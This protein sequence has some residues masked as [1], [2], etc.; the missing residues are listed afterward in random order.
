MLSISDCLFGDLDAGLVA[1]F[2]AE[3]GLLEN[4]MI[5]LT[6][7]GLL[8][9]E[10]VLFFGGVIGRRIVTELSGLFEAFTMV[11]VFLIARSHFL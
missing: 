7:T 2:T 10:V 8:F 6:E 9:E 4:E 11:V 5:F 1:L 3:L